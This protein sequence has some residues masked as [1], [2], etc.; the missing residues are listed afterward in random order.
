MSTTGR[1]R[2]LIVDDDPRIV[3]FIRVK[4]TASGYQVFTAAGGE[5]ALDVVRDSRPDIMILDIIMPG[6]DGFKVLQ[7]VRGSSSM[8]VIALSARSEN[9]PKA[10]SLGACDFI[11][12]PFDVDSLVTMIQEKLG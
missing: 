4:L 9:G 11:V 2:I 10:L 1:Q 8:P 12:K 6:M 7:Q 5:E 3:R